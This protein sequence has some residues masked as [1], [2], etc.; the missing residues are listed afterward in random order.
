MVDAAFVGD[1]HG[2]TH[3][4]A[5]VQ[6]KAAALAAELPPARPGSLV[7][8]AF[9]H[10][11]AA[12]VTALVATWQRGHAVALPRDARRHAVGPTLQ[13]PE[14][15]AFLHDTGAG[16]GF[17]VPDR[18]WPAAADASAI[19]GGELP[20]GDVVVCSPQADGRMER[21][22]LAASTLARQVEAFVAAGQVPAGAVL[23][24]TLAP[25]HPA[26]LVPGVL[27]PLHA[28][29]SLVA[30]VGLDR[31][32]LCERLVAARATH[33]LTSP[34][35]L[36]ALARLP[37]GALPPLQR[38]LVTTEPDAATAARCR[39]VHRL[40]LVVL[41]PA[42]ADEAASA[43]LTTALLAHPGVDDVAAVRVLPPIEP[44]PRWFVAAAGRDLP[45]AELAAI[46]AA[47]CHG[48]PPP[49]LTTVA[50]LPRDVN[51][52]LPPS[53]VLHACGR[54]G[55]GAVPNRALQWGEPVVDGPTW[56]CTVA[57]PRDFAGFEGH[58]VGHPVLSGVVQLHD[59]VL[60][61]LQRAAGRAITVT[62]YGEL[63]FLARIQPGE[64]LDVTVQA[65]ADGRSASFVLARGDVRCTTGR[66]AWG[67]S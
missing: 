64:T 24:T 34:D 13:L 28:G 60:P 38:V 48:E 49:V 1:R 50:Q 32:A 61:A 10:D 23:A 7:A 9:E 52:M 11:H 37:A 25:G 40:D 46:A 26:T 2:R 41:A 27:G 36:R 22:A 53:A 39:H 62:D 3:A 66:A 57:L 14:V 67:R 16:T 12:F 56:R 30:A 17:C 6:A 18:A 63:K 54:T 15:A 5:A 21:R 35:R 51:G 58:F 59:V 65:N 42:A 45:R 47:V 31:A 55:D 33:L 8:Y 44:A 19:A 29:A 4:L 43:A 20:I